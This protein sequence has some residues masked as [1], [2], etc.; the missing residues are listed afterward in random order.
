VGEVPIEH[1][2]PRDT[3]SPTTHAPFA[4][5]WNQVG[6]TSGAIKKYAPITTSATYSFI[7]TK[8]LGG[9]TIDQNCDASHLSTFLEPDDNS[10]IP[11][12]NRPNA[13]SFFSFGQYTAQ[14]NG[15]LVDLRHGA[16]LQAINGVHANTSTINTT[17]TR[18]FGTRYVYNV[19]KSTSP[20]VDAALDFVGV[21]CGGPGYICNNNAHDTLLTFGIVPLALG[22]TGAGLPNSHCRLNPTPL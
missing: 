17:P 10:G 12:A 11:A 3:C 14:S 4:T 20:Q 9:A 1:A 22:G 2:R 13:I 19:T 16:T 7:N 15:V 6:G 5:N 18:F 8:L 21:K